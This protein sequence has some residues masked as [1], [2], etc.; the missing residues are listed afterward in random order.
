[1]KL[2]QDELLSSLAFRFNLRLYILVNSYVATPAASAVETS[3]L[4]ELFQRLLMGGEAT[5]SALSEVAPRRS[6]PP[7]HRHALWTLVT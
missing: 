5:A 3:L 4:T 6:R 7:N 2:K 1:L